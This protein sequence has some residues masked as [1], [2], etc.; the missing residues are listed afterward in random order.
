MQIC[1]LGQFN[2]VKYYLFFQV[3]LL[4]LQSV[5]F[6][7]MKSDSSRASDEHDTCCPVYRLHNERLNK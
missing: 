3:E 7:F 2:Y 4:E 6:N 5:R 1:Q